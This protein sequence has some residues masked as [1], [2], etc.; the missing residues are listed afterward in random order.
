MAV[1]VCELD[2]PRHLDEDSGLST[3][4]LVAKLSVSLPDD[5]LRDLREA[6]QGNVSAFV[7]SAVR[8][9]LD[10]KH[11]RAVIRELEEQVGPADEAE[12]ARLGALLA[13]AK[14]AS[15]KASEGGAS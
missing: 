3:M 1:L 10:R 7:A 5:L 9:E 4:E 8:H 14:A 12:V 13:E 6:A 11:L 15:A 2:S